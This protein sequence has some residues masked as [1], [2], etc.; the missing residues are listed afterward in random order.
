MIEAGDI[1]NAVVSGEQVRLVMD[2]QVFPDR[3]CGQ[4]EHG[5]YAFID[6]PDTEADPDD[7]YFVSTDGG[8]VWGPDEHGHLRVP[9]GKCDVP[10]P[11]PWE[12]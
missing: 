12:M 7:M 3:T 9:V 6:L 2:D 10:T 11:N 8:T 1:F 4:W 5:W